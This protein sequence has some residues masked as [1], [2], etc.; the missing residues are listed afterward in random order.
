MAIKKFI[1][2]YIILNKRNMLNSKIIIKIIDFTVNRTYATLFENHE[3]R[4][5]LKSRMSNHTLILM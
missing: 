2:S 3:V 1:K 4:H 5:W